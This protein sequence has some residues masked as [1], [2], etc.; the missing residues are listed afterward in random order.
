MCTIYYRKGRKKMKKVKVLLCAAL[1]FTLIASACLGAD[2]LALKDVDYATDLGKSIQKL[3]DAGVVNGIPQDDGSFVYGADR[4]ITRAEFCKMINITF[5]FNVAAENVFTDVDSSKWYYP[6]VL[7]AVKQGY[8][9][10][11]GDGTFG[12]EDN[13][14]REQ[15][16]VIL[17]R[18]LAKKAETV[19]QIKDTISSWAKSA[20]ENIVALG[21][22]PLEENGTFRAMDYMTRGE[23]ALAIDDFV[24]TESEDT[25]TED[26]ENTK[27][28]TGGSTA[29][30]SSTGGSH[31]GGS[32]DSVEPDSPSGPSEEPQPEPDPEPAPPTQ[33]EI[34]TSND[35]YRRVE[36]ILEDFQDKI[37]DEVLKLEDNGDGTY[38]LYSDRDTDDF[39]PIN[40]GSILG[41]L[42]KTA[43]DVYDLKDS[44]FVVSN[45]YV[46]S[47]YADEIDSIK[48]QIDAMSDAEF[49][50]FKH[51]LNKI[52]S[53]YMMR[54]ADLFNINLNYR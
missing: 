40:G 33:A 26:K 37:D 24:K 30:G 35:I 11:R 18:I 42:R 9:K 54:L 3:V 23:F 31:T 39:V 21:Y 12:G 49:E 52:N 43:Q 45:E 36:L 28:S 16:C 2:T 20:V 34:D 1:V 38:Q 46:R 10:G 50:L 7:Y 14:T 17:D 41:L 6:H 29:G 51:E 27:P 48:G 53:G 13:I 47:T 32:S 15:V 4:Y 8:I 19:P 5:G 22:I 44:G 25:K